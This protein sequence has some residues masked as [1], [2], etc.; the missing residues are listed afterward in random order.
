MNVREQMLHTLTTWRNEWLPKDGLHYEGPADLILREG[1]WHRVLRTM[2][3]LPR[4]CFA[5]AIG[6][7]AMPGWKYVEGYALMP[8]PGKR[9]TAGE[10]VVHH[11]WVVNPQGK[12]VEVTWP[13]P[14]RC[15]RGI[16]FDV[17][18]ADDATWNGDAAVIN[19]PHRGHPLLRQPWTGEPGFPAVDDDAQERIRFA[20]TIVRAL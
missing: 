14:G 16:V 19:D 20:A 8:L 12:S 13:E 5:N 15:Y 2:K 3:G 11:A 4:H 7:A 6:Y 18:R 17:G 9:P 10:E 1:E